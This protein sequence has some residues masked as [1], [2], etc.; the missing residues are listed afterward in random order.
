MGGSE[1]GRGVAVEGE[2]GCEAGEGTDGEGWRVGVDREGEGVG[3]WE[4][5]CGVEDGGKGRARLLARS[6]S[7]ETRRGEGGEGAKSEGGR[8]GETI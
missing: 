8:E 7:R 3:V 6:G 1:G 5:D 2:G 4:R